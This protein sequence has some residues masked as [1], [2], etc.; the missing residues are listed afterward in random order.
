M[1]W[2]H[3]FTAI[4]LGAIAGIALGIGGPAT[5]PEPAQA[6]GE[7]IS[8]RIA[9][10]QTNEPIEG[11]KV[12]VT[13]ES[14]E[15]VK[16]VESNEDG[17][18]TVPLPAPGTYTVTIDPKTL[19]KNIE[20][21]DKKATS[22]TVQVLT[23]NRAAVAFRLTDGSSLGPEQNSRALQRLLDGV[24]FGLIIAITA[25]GLSLIFGTTGLTNFAHGELVAIGAFVAWGVNVSLGAPLW[26]G[27]IAAVIAGAAVGAANELA[28]WRPLRK[29]GVGLVAMLVG[30]IGL[31]LLLRNVLLI[32]VGGRTEAYDVPTQTQIDLGPVSAT[33]RD[34]TAMAICAVVLVG[35]AVM[36]KSTRIGKAMRAVADNR[37]LAAASGINVNR[38]VLVIWMMAGALAALGGVIYGWTLDLRYDMGF[39]LLLVM[40]AGV[41]LG[42][43]GNAYGALVGSLIIGII[44]QVST[45]WLPSDVK[46]AAGLAVLIAVLLFRPS[47]LFG[48][49][50]RI[51]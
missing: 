12:T 35:V 46:Y 13:T 36:L 28:V 31:A 44:V 1:R 50:Q 38:V 6:A 20:L 51:G 3:R 22:K 11:V 25:I 2:L 34:L 7:T 49:K 48:A 33:P 16:A 4:A 45:L 15:L 19:P 47:G 40:F 8:G 42:G 32:I 27:A 18:Y 10:S 39:T 37:D 21:V 43:L 5:S 29:R 14:G 23:S 26:L 24:R 17:R 9:V 41:T 30:S